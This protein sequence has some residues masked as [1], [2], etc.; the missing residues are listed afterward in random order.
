MDPLGLTLHGRVPLAAHVGWG[1]PSLVVA[2]LT[3]AAL[4][5][6]GWWQLRREL[7]ARFPTSRAAAFLAGTATL[8][9]ALASP[10]D[11]MADHLLHLHMTQHLLLMLVA[12]PLLL[13]A[14]PTAPLLRGL[15]FEL[16]RPLVRLLGREPVR[17]AGVWLTHPVRCWLVFVLVSATWHLPSLYELAL[18]HELWHDVEHACFLAA[19]LLFWWPVVRPWPS[20]P[21]WSRW[22]I[23]PYLL[24]ACLYNG[25]L[26]AVFVFSDRVLYPSYAG[27]R[28]WGLS[29]LADQALA[30]AIM[31]IP[32]SLAM[33]V[34]VVVVGYRLLES[35]S[36]ASGRGP[37]V[38]RNATRARTSSGSRFLP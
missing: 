7:P 33:L 16:R 21:R 2:I 13:L 11:S 27:P 20:L 17:A 38:S 23:A 37:S 31:W 8:L 19:G 4:Y 29:S 5:G 35:G 30:G 18:H 32:G 6:R 26:S 28:P 24:L 15:P 3:P 36:S 22:S 10:L 25:I 9:V 12:P 14:W 1:E 34:P